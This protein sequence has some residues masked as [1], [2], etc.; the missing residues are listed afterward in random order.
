MRLVLDSNV[1]IAAFAARGLC[2]ALF[3]FCLEGHEII[4]C[5]EIIDEVKRNLRK[6][7]KVPESLI[8]EI[9]SYLRES[10]LVEKPVP[11]E[12]GI[13]EDES[14]LPVLGVGAASGS[15]Y[16]ITGDKALLSLKKYKDIDII[17]PRSFWEIIKG[18]ANN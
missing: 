2:H 11:V 4:L 14:D 3:E 12:N 17:N 10:T 1:I 15:S 7:I 6:K 8:T 9:E 18:K 16:I 5:E 13:F